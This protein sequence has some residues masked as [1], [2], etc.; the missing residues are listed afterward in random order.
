VKIHKLERT[1]VVPISIGEAF[2]FFSNPRNLERLT[3]GIVH[4]QFLKPP[5]EKVSP[6]TVLEYRLRLYGLPVKW[7]TRIETVEPPTRFVD[8]QDK[9]PYAWWRH[10][11]SFREVD[12]HHTEIRD[13]VEFGMP[14][15]PLG[16]LA[17]RLLVA[18]SLRQIFNYREA[19][20]RELFPDS[21]DR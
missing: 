7:R 15:G 20:L 17:Y 21:E 19:A 16:E 5:P 4:F 9:G 1:Q 10:T 11:H 18:G 14:L 8:V 2:E 6:G 3:P 12:A 13:Q